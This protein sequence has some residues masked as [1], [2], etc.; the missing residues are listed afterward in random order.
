[1]LKKLSPL[2]GIRPAA[3]LLGLGGLIIIFAGLTG[4]AAEQFVAIVIAVAII[5]LALLIFLFTW[6]QRMNEGIGQN[7]PG[8]RPELEGAIEEHES[9]SEE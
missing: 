8:R 2:L 7:R 3:G 5:A 1:M 4:G 9:D 6:I